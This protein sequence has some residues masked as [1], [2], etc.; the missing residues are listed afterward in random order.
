VS[1]LRFLIDGESL[2][3]QPQLG[4]VAGFTGRD[5]DAVRH[6][7][8]ELEREGISAPERVPSFYL[9]APDILVQEGA[10]DVGHARTSGEAE[11]ALLYEGADVY[12]TLASDHTD[13][14]AETLDIALSKEVCPKVFASTA[15]RYEEVA[16]A[17]DELTLR[18][19]I[20]EDGE[21]VL[22][23]EGVASTLIAPDDL[24]GRMP[25]AR[26]PERFALLT[27]TVAV[28]RAIRGAARFWAELTHPGSGRAIEL[29]YRIRPLDRLL[30]G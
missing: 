28:R 4:V 24:L 7:I 26:R 27:G 22:Y 8:E 12:V 30:G 1:P 3:L 14:Q 2:E 21:R 23:Q 13:R 20:E 11:I 10:I 29:D 16:D 9:I 15:W 18:S 17:W 5:A 25:F 6:H 19:W